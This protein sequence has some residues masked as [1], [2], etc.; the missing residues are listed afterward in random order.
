M[1]RLA[2]N[3][4][5]LFGEVPFRERFRAAARMGF[6]G[7]EYLFPY[8]HGPEEIAGELRSHDLTQVLFNAPAGDWAAGERGFAALPGQEE[9]FRSSIEHMIPYID[10][11]GAKLIHVMAGIIAASDPLATRTYLCNLDY[12]ARRLAGRRV[13]LLIEP[14]N[15][16]DV[17]GYFLSDYDT[18]LTL[19]KTLDI[20]SVRLQFDIYH[21]QII[22]G[23]VTL[24]LRQALPRIGHIQIASVPDRHEPDSGE[25][26]LP[27]IF[28]VLEESGYDGWVGCEY[29]PRA[30]T[31]DGLSWMHR[32]ITPRGR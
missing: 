5:Y 11:T 32:W 27:Y 12:A 24:G 18:A 29:R 7:V 1:I 28:Q 3:L 10:A 4:S 30:R 21:R 13:T 25:L 9:R 17:P 16:R 23:D 31:E 8:D 14:L 22:R 26:S 2:A 6:H 19:L 20:E 15:G